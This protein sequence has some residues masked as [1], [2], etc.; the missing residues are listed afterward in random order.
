MV[1]TTTAV[2][3][4]AI[5]PSRALKKKQNKHSQ[6]ENMQYFHWPSY[7][8]RRG[9]LERRCFMTAGFSL[10]RMSVV[11]HLCI[12]LIGLSCSPASGGSPGPGVTET[13][14]P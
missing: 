8:G 9:A 5:P 10:N 2:S 14:E 7:S 6:A 13:L 11:C 1:H 4:D 3:V 12:S